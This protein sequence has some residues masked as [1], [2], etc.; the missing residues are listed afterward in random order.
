MSC[1]LSRLKE[2][3]E[4][5]SGGG[6]G[7]DYD[8]GVAH[9]KAAPWD[10]KIMQGLLEDFIMI[11]DR[12]CAAH[13]QPD[14]PCFL[15]LLRFAADRHLLD[16]TGVTRVQLQEWIGFLPDGVR[17]MAEYFLSTAPGSPLPRP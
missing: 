8:V 13:D 16:F 7:W 15:N 2:W 11:G 12:G 6:D 9:R 3:K 1:L 5:G 4:K 14:A 17:I 10:Y